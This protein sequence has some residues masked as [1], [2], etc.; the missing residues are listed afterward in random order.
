MEPGSC[1][2]ANSAVASSLQVHGKYLE[3][4]LGTGVAFSYMKWETCHSYLLEKGLGTLERKD[5]KQKQ[6]K[7]VGEKKGKGRK[8]REKRF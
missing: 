8:W 2:R 3:S 1:R 6:E 4:H 7:K 5:Y